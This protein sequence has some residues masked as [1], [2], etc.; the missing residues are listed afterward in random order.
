MPGVMEGLQ[1]II[2][3]LR[4]RGDSAQYRPL[5][6]GDAWV[7][8]DNAYTWRRLLRI[9][10]ARIIFIGAILFILMFGIAQVCLIR[11][12]TLHVEIVAN[13]FS[14]DTW[15]LRALKTRTL[16]PMVM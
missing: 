14:L 4:G 8:N 3:L 7:G 11:F 5:G 9:P 1:D 2:Q 6:S 10:K 12:L 16:T 13:R 15:R